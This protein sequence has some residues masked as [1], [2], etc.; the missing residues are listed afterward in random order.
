MFNSR[1]LI[2]VPPGETIKEQLVYNEMPPS[3]LAQLT[4][5]SEEFIMDL[6]DGTARLTVDVAIRLE[7]AIK[8]PANFWLALEKNY[9][10]DLKKIE[11]ENFRYNKERNAAP[12]FSYK[13]S[14]KTFT[15]N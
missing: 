6:L 5:F 13:Q 15:L 8:V 14:A 2:A 3:K 1:T 12:K 4:A 9:R 7:K 11:A 10:E